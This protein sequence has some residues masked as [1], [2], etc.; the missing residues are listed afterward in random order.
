MEF[1]PSV[2]NAA[3]VSFNWIYNKDTY[4]PVGKTNEHE[5]MAICYFCGLGEEL[6]Q[7]SGILIH[8]KP[9][10]WALIHGGTQRKPKRFFICESC[11]KLI[12]GASA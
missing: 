8:S 6:S 10:K 11:C 1:Q 3:L 12:V 4:E 9:K 7:P 5:V 2:D